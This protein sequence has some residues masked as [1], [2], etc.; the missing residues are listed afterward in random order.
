M[1]LMAG[2]L[3]DITQAVNKSKEDVL[4]GKILMDCLES[5]SMGK[6]YNYVDIE[7]KNNEENMMNIVQRLKDY[8]YSVDCEIYK[9]DGYIDIT[10]RW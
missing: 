4:F 9:E 10:V 2:Q 1:Q 8:N 5:A 3:R 6:D 7:L